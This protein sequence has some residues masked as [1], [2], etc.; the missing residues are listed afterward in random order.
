MR[1]FLRWQKSWPLCL[2]PYFGAARFRPGAFVTVQLS[3]KP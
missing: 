3:H 2:A 1:M